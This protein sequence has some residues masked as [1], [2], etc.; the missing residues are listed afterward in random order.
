MPAPVKPYHS[1]V[2]QRLLDRKLKCKTVRKGYRPGPNLIFLIF[3]FLMELLA[4]Q[5]SSFANNQTAVVR[6]IGKDVYEAL[7]TPEAAL[8]RILILMRPG[9]VGLNVCPVRECEV[10]GVERHDQIVRTVH[11]GESL[12]HG[13]LASNVPHEL[14]VGDTVAMAHA[15][16]VDDGKVCFLDSRWVMAI[17]A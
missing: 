11:A 3:E 5:M 9:G 10:D 6:S 12:D 13:G 7:K 15:F 17:E 1:L 4:R 14:L 16:L 2:L 8:K